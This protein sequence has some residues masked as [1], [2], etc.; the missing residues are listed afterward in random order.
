ML[1]PE[2]GGFYTALF[3]IGTSLVSYKASAWRG[4]FYTALFHLLQYYIMNTKTTP[5]NRR[6]PKQAI[7]Y[8]ILITISHYFQSFCLERGFLHSPIPSLTVLHYEKTELI[9]YRYDAFAWRRG[10]LHSPTLYRH[11]FGIIQCFCL[12][13]GFLHSPIPSLTV[14][15]YD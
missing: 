11:I 12:K 8:Y 14:L 5:N 10:F 15:H 6:R 13:R 3:H 9:F 7:S 1:L 2:G 4:G